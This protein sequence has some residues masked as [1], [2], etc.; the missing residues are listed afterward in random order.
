MKKH[1][2]ILGL[3]VL[4][5]ACAKEAQ[6]VL[7]SVESDTITFTTDFTKVT[8]NGAVNEWEAKDSISVFS[9]SNSA[10][11]GVAI[12]NNIVYY[13]PDAGAVAT[14]LP[15]DKSASVADKY[16]AYYPKFLNHPSKLNEDASIGF[17]GVAV[18]DPVNDY[19]FLP[20]TVN[21]GYTAS[22]NPATRKANINVGPY[23]Y[24]VA[25]A[26]QNSGDAIPLTFH[27]L[28]PMLE[29]GFIGKGTITEFTAAYAD[30]ATDVIGTDKSNWITAKGIFNPLTGVLTT[31][32]SNSSA[33]HKIIVTMDKAVT[34]S[35]TE[36]T[37]FPMTVGRFNIT[38]G[39]N[40]IFKDA[41]GYS[42]T[43]TIWTDK[44]VSGV[45]TE[46]KPIHLYQKVNVPYLVADKET[47]PAFGS[48]GASAQLVLESTAG[49][50]SVVSKPE[51][52]S[53]DKT[54]GADGATLTVTA[55]KNSNVEREGE[56]VLGCSKGPR[57]YIAVS[58]EGASASE[59]YRILKSGIEWPASKI[60]YVIS[61]TGDTLAVVTREFLGSSNPVLV[62]KVYKT[63]FSGGVELGD[64]PF[65][66]SA[67]GATMSSST[68]SGTVGDAAYT[69]MV[70]VSP[71]GESNPLVKVENKIFTVNGYKTTKMGNGTDI[72]KVSPSA[73]STP[74]VVV[75]TASDGGQFYI[76]N[77][78][79]VGVTSN[80]TKATFNEGFAPEGWSM[81]DSTTYGEIKTFIGNDTNAYTTILSSGLFTR[82]TY[83]L[84]GT[85]TSQLAYV[86]TW[87]TV[88][89]AN[90][91]K[92]FMIQSGKAPSSN[93]QALTAMFEVL[94]FKKLD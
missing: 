28:L 39:L 15:A 69:D 86:N 73:K 63:D 84:N 85:A 38:K 4:A 42:F 91:L 27:P 53:L 61:A 81:V 2:A 60:R 80:G 32:N 44:T 25:D 93:S 66:I 58:Q 49:N 8:T 16:I 20:V 12:D 19:R 10:A 74:A 41:H 82:N 47:I 26:P 67:D 51:W 70:L 43:K 11:A 22:V 14:F 79:A 89:D 75:G 31:T 77:A 35:A 72:P 50:W 7:S 55:T 24:A 88:P 3:S 23:F 56:I 52:I 6:P 5:L 54:S 94:V 17:S 36:P 65:Y 21:S 48:A 33:Y 64:D 45:T 1:F 34:L 71:S 37:R 18:G 78:Y 59:N 29:F 62:T 68:P 92:M 13:T 87:S 83:K 90:K 9:L 57:C 76:Y 40:L 30:K 46:G